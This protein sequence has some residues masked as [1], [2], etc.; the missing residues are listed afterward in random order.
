M[1][2][3]LDNSI[4]NSSNLSK[5]SPSTTSSPPPKKSHR[6]GSSV[7]CPKDSTEDTTIM[8]DKVEQMETTTVNTTAGEG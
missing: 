6:M 2:R 1:K 3:P 5:E 7:V 4:S 8:S